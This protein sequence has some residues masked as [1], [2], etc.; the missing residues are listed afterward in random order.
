MYTSGCY[1]RKP[2]SLLFYIYLLFQFLFI[3]NDHLSGVYFGVLRI[4]RV[5][6]WLFKRILDI[7]ISTLLN[8][9]NNKINYALGFT[10]INNK[11]ISSGLVASEAEL[12]CVKTM[13][14]T[15]H[16][17]GFLTARH[18]LFLASLGVVV[19]DRYS[20]NVNRK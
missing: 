17:I 18:S 6:T 7:C 19:S 2:N 13:V 5:N 16:L 10:R 14:I 1:E 12:T 11:V 8:L 9:H 3:K 4:N 15:L 20:P